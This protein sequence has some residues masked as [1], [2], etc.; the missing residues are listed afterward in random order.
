LC[1]ALPCPYFEYTSMNF[2][3]FELLVLVSA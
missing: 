2:H 3:N 1:R